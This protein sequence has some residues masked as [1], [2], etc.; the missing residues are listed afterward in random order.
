MVPV[1]MNNR[2]RLALC[3]SLFAKERIRGLYEKVL[4]SM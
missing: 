1:I 4:C 2:L 3:R